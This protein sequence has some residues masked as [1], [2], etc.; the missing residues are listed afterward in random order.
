MKKTYKQQKWIDSA[1]FD[2]DSLFGCFGTLFVVFATIGTIFC[3]FA[4]LVN[5]V[6]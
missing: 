3:I 5:L 6:Q 1:P 4:E 2:T